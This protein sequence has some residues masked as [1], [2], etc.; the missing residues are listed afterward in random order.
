MLHWAT[1]KGVS[2]GMLLTLI[3]R[4]CFFLVSE[5]SLAAVKI[6]DKL[7]SNSLSPQLIQMAL[8]LS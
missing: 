7:V 3:K 2:V 1:K 8:Y 6:T 4:S 5:Y